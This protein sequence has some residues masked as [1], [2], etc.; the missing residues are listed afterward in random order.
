M[1][2]GFFVIILLLFVADLA[3]ILTNIYIYEST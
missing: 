2:A 3:N 1:F